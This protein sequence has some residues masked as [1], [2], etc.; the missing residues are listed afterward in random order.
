MFRK[1]ARVQER[2]SPP[3]ML[4][5]DAGAAG[6]ATAAIV[7][8]QERE[9]AALLPD[10]L[11]VV[12]EGTGTGR[13]LLVAA[14][15]LATLVLGVRWTEGMYHPGEEVLFVGVPCA[16]LAWLAHR[17]LLRRRK[18]FRL[19]KSGIT[20]EV[21]P[22]AGGAPRVTHVLWAEI[23]DYTVSVD[24][25]KAYL[26]V[27]S[28]RGYTLTLHDRPPRLTTRELI[29]RFMEQV[30]RHARAPEPQPRRPGAP[31][32]DV[33]GE[34]RPI[35]A[36][37]LTLFAVVVVTAAVET[38]LDPSF[39]Q[40]M[41]GLAVLSLIALGVHLWWTLDDS[42]VAVADRDSRRLTARL[43]RWLRGVLGIRVS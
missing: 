41:T 4:A 25:E 32:P 15:L 34:R 40:K 19:V 30:D 35:L 8:P 37:C 3:A 1:H 31:L 39:A 11:R 13:L 23:A 20:A 12:I 43:R 9:I 36:G 22:L 17:N 2:D 7:A 6:S 18:E 29:R 28:E 27:V 38:L 24:H 21:W 10:G 14:G 33:T 42:D 26:R 5:G 16:V